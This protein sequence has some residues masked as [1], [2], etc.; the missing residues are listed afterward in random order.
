MSAE[1]LREDKE[2]RRRR[3]P[4]V[5][6]RADG[7]PRATTERGLSTKGR[8]TPSRRRDEDEHEGNLLTR[9]GGGIR[10]Y[11]EGVRS[12]LGKVAWPTREETTRLTI[13]VLATLLISAII[14]GIISAVFTE[15]F[16]IGLNQPVILFAF[17]AVA[18]VAGLIVFRVQSRRS[19]Y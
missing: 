13:I 12:E 5:R 6:N 9:T 14:L 17:I 7:S 10:E 11:L 4:L 1:K 15:L 19:S 16:R 18:V 2:G 8:T 3:I